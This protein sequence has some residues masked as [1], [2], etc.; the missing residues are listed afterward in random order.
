MGPLEGV[1]VLDLSRVLTGPY[2]T[3][4]LADFGAEVI[5]VEMP[6]RGDDTRGYGPP[7]IEGESCYFMSVNRN[8]KSITLNL[9]SPEGMEVLLKLARQADVIIEN[10]RPGTT[11]KLKI[12]YEDIREINPRVIYCSISGFGQDGPH[13]ARPG[14]DLIL[15]GMGGLMGITGEEEGPPVKVGVAIADITA[16]MFAAYGIVSA[17]YARERTGVGQYIDTSLLESQVALL[18]YMAGNYF[19]TG[20]NP[21]KMG[22]AHPNIVPYQAFRAAD[23]KYINI[24][25]GSERIWQS[26]C[27][28]VGKEEWLD[29]PLCRTNKERVENRKVVVDMVADLI[30]ARTSEEWL[31]IFAEAGVPC[32]PIYSLSEVFSDPQVLHREML[33]RVPHPRAGEVALTGIPI[34]MSETPGAVR[35]HPPLLGEHT[36]EVLA[37]LGYSPED[38]KAL[39]EKGAI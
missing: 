25:V 37:D 20:K 36:E 11:R 26:F 27:Q 8:K 35:S 28:A 38:I 24:A 5:K 33:V 29:D 34:K 19:G 4:M 10:F 7:F 30:K 12:A 6:G 22:S 17:L 2:C 18:T 39:R 23:G 31:K 13:A 15:Q 16:G 3:M 32:G 21:P 1:R 14:F 9:K